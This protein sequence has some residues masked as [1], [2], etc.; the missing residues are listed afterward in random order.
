MA[1]TTHHR[2]HPAPREYWL[3][4]AILAAITAVEVAIAYLDLLGLVVPS[5][6]V[7]SAAKFAIVVGWFMH[8]RFEDP[9]YRRLFYVGLIATPILFAVVLFTFG[10]LIG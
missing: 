6:L 1:E 4:A 2:P 10:V 9:T 3:I 8:L 7:L 5:L